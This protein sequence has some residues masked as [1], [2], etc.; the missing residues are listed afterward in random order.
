M[1]R[2]SMYLQMA[3]LLCAALT[4]PCFAQSA[5]EEEAI[6]LGE[7]TITATKKPEKVENVSESV[8]VITKDQIAAM[9]VTNVDELIGMFAG[10]VSTRDDGNSDA[11]GGLMLRGQDTGSGRVLVLVDGMILNNGDSG[12]ANFNTVDIDNVE[13]IEVIRGASSVMHGTN[14]MGG[15]VNII[16]K[17]PDTGEWKAKTNLEAGGRNTY[18]QK[19]FLEGGLSRN[20]ALSFSASNKRSGSFNSEFPE[21][22][23]A[24][25]QDP[26]NT[27]IEERRYFVKAEQF[28]G[29]ADTSLTYSVGVYDDERHRGEAFNLTNNPNGSM[30]SFDTQR[31][32]IDFS[33]PGERFSARASLGYNLEKYESLSERLRNNR[34]TH[35]IVSSDRLNYGLDGSMA[36][37]GDRH[38][39]TVGAGYS[40][41]SQDA[42]DDYQWSNDTDV[43]TDPTFDAFNKGDL[44]TL[45]A[46]VHDTVALTDAADLQMGLRFDDAKVKDASYNL[47]GSTTVVALNGKGWD[48]VSPKLGLILHTGQN[49]RVRVQYNHAFHAPNLESMTLNMQRGG[50]FWNSNPDLKPEKS[51]SYEIGFEHNGKGWKHSISAYYSKAKDYIDIMDC[52]TAMGCNI[53]DRKYMNVGQ[54]DFKGLEFEMSRNVNPNTLVYFNASYTDTEVKDYPSD[55]PLVGKRLASVPE[56]TGNLGCT[57]G[58]PND[59]SLGLNLRY[60]GLA[61]DDN[62]NTV[63][64]KA[65]YTADVRASKWVSKTDAVELQINN[66]FK[67]IRLAGSS[68]DYRLPGVVLTLGYTRLY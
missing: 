41:A 14:G 19:L 5:P 6:D 46:Y 57:Y 61:Y 37:T 30:W 25:N 33:N 26:E 20:L 28:L 52:T 23:D 24:G 51:D 31:Y 45:F 18:T 21:D 17:A 1:R 65:Y 36:W 40:V 68:S 55:T 67:P 60:T 44:E 39:L 42:K 11:R 16:T 3:A 35:W 34:Y 58:R 22:R 15:I 8:E 62:A 27:T 54:V 49:S 4:T 9:P 13:R 38:D 59:E 43:R 48:H 32:Q 50:S 53:G 12:T 63:P 10:A 7:I 66:I 29:S 2:V 56:F 64:Q 47:S